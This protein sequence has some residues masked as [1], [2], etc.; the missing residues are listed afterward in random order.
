MKPLSAPRPLDLESFAVQTEHLEPRSLRAYMRL[1]LHYWR[2]GRLFREDHDLAGICGIHVMSFRRMK[3][4]LGLLFDVDDTG[5]WRD[6]ELEEDRNRVLRTSAVRARAGGVGARTR[7]ARDG[8]GEDGDA[9]ANAMAIAMQDGP[10]NGEVPT[11]SAMANGMANAGASLAL[12]DDDDDS[13]RGESS[14]SSSSSEV[15]GAGGAMA[16][17][18]AIAMSN[19][20]ENGGIPAGSTVANG[21]APATDP[22]IANAM[23]GAA[24]PA[25]LP[26]PAP[27]RQ[28]A[29][30]VVT[31]RE[32]VDLVLLACGDKI[33]PKLREVREMKPL[34][35]MMRDGCDL[36]RDILPVLEGVRTLTKPLETFHARWIKDQVYER[37]ATPDEVLAPV[38]R[39]DN[40]VFIEQGT[41]EWKAWIGYA[42]TLGKT[43]YPAS[44]L[45]GSGGKT[46]WKFPAR[47][48]PGHE[49]GEV[50]AA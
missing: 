15:T 5:L 17:A 43:G 19:G 26:A 33:A 37:R 34:R 35:A 29:Q 38:A 7:W 45:P 10:E 2:Y 32:L 12:S 11:E 40:Q 47:W 25:E 23:A 3:E 8:G 49:A 18:M 27:D 30:P 22:P 6:P 31:D 24:T 16:N 46:G 4:Q 41:P 13:F 28:P 36:R 42:K 44:Q 21:M 20:A 48:P 39:T 14:S 9:M 50:A 1:Q